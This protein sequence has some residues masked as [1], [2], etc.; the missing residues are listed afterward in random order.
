M[1]D[2]ARRAGVS[3]TTV[4]HVLNQTRHVAPE[5]EAAVLAV[6]AATGYV[7]DAVTRS[8]RTVRQRMVGLAMSSIS[9]LYFSDVVRG[10]EKAARA[11]GYS[12][13][14]SET[15]DEPRQELRAVTELLARSVD[16]IILA[17]SADPS[18]ALTYCEQRNVPVVLVDRLLP[19]ELDQIGAESVE[20]TATLVTHLAE[21][22]HTRIGM[23]TSQPGLSTTLERLEGF[24]TGMSRAGLPIDEALIVEGG[25]TA[26]EGERAAHELL[27]RSDRP[28]GL[29]LGNNLMTIGTLRAIRGLGLRVPDDLALASFDDFEWADLFEPR[30]TAIAQPVQEMGEQAF[31]LVTER[32][33]NPDTPVRRVVLAS[34]F[35]HRNSCGCVA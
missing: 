33:E 2:I 19:L 25:A 14:L 16:A 3:A 28:S 23:V 8:M 29:V 22:G 13:L 17:A 18:L 12:I 10:I 32:L 30:L 26:E 5:T 15:H 6:V 4:S 7:P 35:R 24:R 27:G 11:Q 9:N 31:Q 1:A 34:T 20:S 21:L